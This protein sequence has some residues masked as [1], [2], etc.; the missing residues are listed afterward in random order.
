MTLPAQPNLSATSDKLNNSDALR[1]VD[2]SKQSTP[3][4]LSNGLWSRKQFWTLL[5]VTSYSF[6]GSK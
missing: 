2:S 3:P 5:A 1:W 4:Q 6:Q